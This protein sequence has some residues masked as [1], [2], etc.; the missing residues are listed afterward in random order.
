MT[1]LCHVLLRRATEADDGGIEHVSVDL[2]KSL[3]VPD[4]DTERPSHVCVMVRGLAWALCCQ[5]PWR[6]STRV[7]GNKGVGV[8]R[9]AEATDLTVFTLS[10]KVESSSQTMQAL[11]CI[12]NIDTVH[13]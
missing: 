11:G 5:H 1:D 12:C 7:A 3:E 8:S 13:I 6:P 2:Q 10:S 4:P 9:G